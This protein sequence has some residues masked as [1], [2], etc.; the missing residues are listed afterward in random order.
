MTTEQC[1]IG[2][3]RDEDV[4][5]TIKICEAVYNRRKQDGATGSSEGF[6]GS[7]ETQ[8]QSATAL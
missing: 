1:H 4:K 5:R 7:S 8:G 3:M 2:E 6:S